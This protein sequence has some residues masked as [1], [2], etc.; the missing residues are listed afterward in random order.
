MNRRYNRQQ[1][2]KWSVH[3]APEART[4]MLML[5]DRH[6]TL[7]RI[8]DVFHACQGYEHV[9][10]LFLKA[11]NACGTHMPAEER[12]IPDLTDA[13]GGASFYVPRASAR[14]PVA[15]NVGALSTKW[16][17]WRS[18]LHDGDETPVEK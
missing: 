12:D 2:Y 1:V 18:L 17:L 10:S 13:V 3:G 15:V 6:V 5:D 8:E 7:A 4:E 14:G 16:H 9:S 11:L